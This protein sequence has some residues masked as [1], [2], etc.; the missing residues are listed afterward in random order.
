MTR[1]H[2]PAAAHEQIGPQRVPPSNPY[3]TEWAAKDITARL[4]RA[5][6]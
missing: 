4:I 5:G 1:Q 3:A 2:P 6:V